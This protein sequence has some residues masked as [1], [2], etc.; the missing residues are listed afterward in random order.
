MELQPAPQSQCE[1]ILGQPLKVENKQITEAEHLI[2]RLSENDMVN[3]QAPAPRMLATVPAAERLPRQLMLLIGNSYYDSI[4]QSDGDAAP[5][6]DECG[7]RENG[8]GTAGVATRGAAPDGGAPGVA[9]RGAAPAGA[10]RG[11]GGGARTCRDQMNSRALSYITSIDLRRVWIAD[12]EKGL[13]FG[14]TQF[15]HPYTVRERVV[16]NADGTR[17]TVTDNNNPFDTYAAHIFKIQG[18][19]IYEI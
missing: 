12:E 17:R 2:V 6:A 8:R 9:P 11:G 19:K 5:Y 1:L 13:V 18:G 3:F 10:V 16:F 15:R 4:V 7:R 14:L